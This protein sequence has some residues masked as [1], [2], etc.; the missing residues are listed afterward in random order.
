MRYKC[1]YPSAFDIR[2]DEWHTAVYE[3]DFAANI[4]V[5]CYNNDC[6]VGYFDLWSVVSGMYHNDETCR[7]GTMECRGNE[8]KDH[9]NRCP[10]R[11]E[12]R[13]TVDYTGPD[14]GANLDIETTENSV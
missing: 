12:Y 7:E 10:C 11:L 9:N 14:D 6:T 3:P 8:A 2:P 4:H 13:V 1:I 5:D